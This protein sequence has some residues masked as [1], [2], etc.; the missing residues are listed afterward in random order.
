M[1]DNVP[2]TQSDIKDYYQFDHGCQFFC[3]SVETFS[4][5]I[6]EWKQNNIVKLWDKKYR[7]ISD[8]YD[9]NKKDNENNDK[10]D[11][12]NS[13]IND[14][15]NDSFQRAVHYDNTSKKEVDFL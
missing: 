2:L 10:N 11:N 12:E 14:S 5:K 15:K 4:Q 13:S 8:T 3:A 6:N 7:L 1:P 9:N